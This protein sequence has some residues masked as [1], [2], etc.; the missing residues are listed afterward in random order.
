MIIVVGLGNPGMQYEKTRHNMGYWALDELAKLWQIPFLAEKHKAYFGKGRTAGDTAMLLKPT[1][2][3][4]SSG[5]SV[6][7][8]LRFYKADVSNL[9]VVYDDMDMPVGSLRIRLKGGPGTHNGMKSIV[10][11]LGSEDFIRVRVGI[12]K[13]PVNMDTIG[14]V[15]GRPQGE[16]MEALLA[17]TKRAAE[18]VDT[19]ARIGAEAAMQ[20]FN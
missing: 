4:N 20:K 18:A 1:T 3:M 11:E 10:N 12:G 9:V 13:P 14:F 2:F 7:D 5:E 8:V 6:V 16:E 19:I 15:L 17:S